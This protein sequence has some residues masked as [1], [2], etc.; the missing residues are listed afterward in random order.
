MERRPRTND[1]LMHQCSGSCDTIE[2]RQV[3]RSPGSALTLRARPVPNK[4]VA[5]NGVF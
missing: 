5:D 3:K 2:T 1:A 4:E